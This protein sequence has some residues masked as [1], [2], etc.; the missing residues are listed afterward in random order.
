[1]STCNC[2]V[3]ENVNL[4][5]MHTP[6]K[7]FKIFKAKFIEQKNPENMTSDVWLLFK[8]ITVIVILKGAVIIF[9]KFFKKSQ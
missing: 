2:E 5:K 7:L 9:G 4:V 3:G 8:I 1:M 6:L